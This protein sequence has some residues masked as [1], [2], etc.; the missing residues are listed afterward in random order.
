MSTVLS[1][2]IARPVKTLNAV[3]EEIAAGHLEQQVSPAGPSEIRR[4]GYAFN[5][6]A[7]RVREM[8]ARQQAFVADAAHELRSPLTSLRL[9]L[10]ML[11]TH[12]QT[13]SAM[14]QRYL[15]QMEQEVDHLRRLVDHLLALSS[16][17]EGNRL[18][19]THLDLT[20]VLYDL[21]ND[22]SLIVQQASLRLE[23]DI[24]YHLPPVMAN[25][26]QIRIII[27]NLPD[28]AIKYTPAN[29]QIT[30]KAW[31]DND[32]VKVSVADTGIGIPADALPHIFERFYRVDKSHSRQQGGAGL[33]L[34]LVR[35]LV[36]AHGGRVEVHSE[37]GKGSAFV[38]SLPTTKTSGSCQQAKLALETTARQ[39]AKGAPAAVSQGRPG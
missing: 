3:T 9:R 25:A 22:M 39:L 37:P 13:D 11:Q 20:P 35:S 4:L 18:P 32:T 6:M 27:R 28:N 26:E 30:I 36:E 21:M 8:L 31:S 38:V 2:Y 33:G 10:E 1:R 7:E 17:D 5:R 29:G 34:S 15:R 23:T 19:Q 16:L 24:P 12:G 14:S